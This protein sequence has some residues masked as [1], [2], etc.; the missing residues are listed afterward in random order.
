LL[1]RGGSPDRGVESPRKVLANL[2]CKLRRLLVFI[3]A[4]LSLW[5]C[6]HIVAGANVVQLCYPWQH[7][8]HG[9]GSSAVLCN[10]ASIVVFAVVSRFLGTS[11]P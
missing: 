1:Q 2:A 5:S 3:R 4:W 10:V 6:G 9:N 11:Y 8:S 7:C